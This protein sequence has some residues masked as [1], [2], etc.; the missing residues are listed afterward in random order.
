M[1]LPDFK[2]PHTEKIEWMIE[3]AGWAIEPVPADAT[4]DPPLPAYAYS[5]GLP[6][7][8]A[9][10]EIAVLGLTPSASKGLIDLVV[11]QLRGGVEI[12]L[13]VELVGLLDNELRCC[14]AP[15]PR[16]LCGTWFPTAT[17][18]Y[19]GEAFEVVQ[20]IYPD[21]QGFLP[22]E[23]GFDRRLRFAQPV[24]GIMG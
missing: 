21:R 19:R 23:D 11:S 7:S 5:I 17:A 9:F 6:A 1:E 15:I 4:V 14:F 10:P 8:V 3:T 16:Q 24:I 2:I 20:L 18:W 13:G 12:P 22:Y